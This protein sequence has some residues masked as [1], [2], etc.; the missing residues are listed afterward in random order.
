MLNFN[1]VNASIIATLIILF[2]KFI[3]PYFKK[4]KMNYYEEVKLGLLL[5]GYAFRDDKV[6]SIADTV[7]TIVKEMESLRLASEDKH[8]IA[9][10][11]TFKALLDEFNIKLEDEVIDLL[12]KLAVSLLPK[13]NKE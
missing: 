1:I 7:L 12:I 6:K 13:T 9:F 11:K 5:F 10:E 3:L 2:I 4:T 8:D